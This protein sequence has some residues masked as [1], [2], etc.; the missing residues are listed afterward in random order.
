MNELLIINNSTNNTTS[1]VI[2]SNNTNNSTDIYST[3]ATLTDIEPA[4]TII[5]ESKRKNSCCYYGICD[6]NC[7]CNAGCQ[8]NCSFQEIILIIICLPCFCLSQAE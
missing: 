3:P 4:P 2:E 6:C 1:L 5:V 7:D 8:G